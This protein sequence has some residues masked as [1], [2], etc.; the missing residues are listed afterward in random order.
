M[1]TEALRKLTPYL[2]EGKTYDKAIE[3][4]YP[5]KFSEKLSGN[6]NELPPLSEEQLHQ[7]TN[8]VVKRAISQT[9]K[10]IN[11]VIKKYGAPHQIK[12]ECATDLAKNFDDRKKIEKQQ[13]KM[14]NIMKK[15]RASLKNSALQIQLVSR[16]L[17][18]N[19]ASSKIANVYI[20]VGRLT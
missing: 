9:R 4:A 1:S 7:L 16:S 6:K 11:A 14:P 12:I 15:S 18:I 17:N 13:K 2:L 19:Y 20:A 3:L 10:V 5:G 8:P